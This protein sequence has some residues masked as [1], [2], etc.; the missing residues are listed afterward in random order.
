MRIGPRM[1]DTDPR[2]GPTPFSSEWNDAPPPP[3]RPRRVPVRR[4]WLPSVLPAWFPSER[5]ISAAL[6][7]V[8]I[9]STAA[10]SSAGHGMRELAAPRVA[11][12]PNIHSV[13][14]NGQPT[15]TPSGAQIVADAST[16]AVTA[17]A[18]AETPTPPVALPVNAGVPSVRG[19][20]SA[21][22]SAA[23]SGSANASG[24]GSAS[25]SAQSSASASAAGSQPASS[26]SGSAVAQG[27]ATQTKQDGPFPR[28]ADGNLFPQN[29]I[30]AYYG[31]PD[32][33]PA[34]NLMGVLG[35]DTIDNTYAK[36]MDQVAA[37]QQADPN[38]NVIPAF[39]FI[40]TVAQQ[41]PQPDGSYLTDTDPDFIQTYIDFAA[42]HDMLVFID[43]Q[44]GMRGVHDEVTKLLP[45]L[46]EPNVMLAIDPEFAIHGDEKPGEDF[47][48]I[49]ADDVNWTM[50]TLADLSAEKGIPNKVL[51]VHQFRYDMISDKETIENVP[52]IELVLHADGHGPPSL[53]KETYGVVVTQWKDRIHF[54][55]GF[56]VFYNRDDPDLNKY[57]DI[58]NMT[59]DEILQLDPIPY[60][61]SYQ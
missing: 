15:Q 10:F 46:A 41:N 36:L 8:I 12:D 23:A 3:E 7:L 60:Y 9:L 39:E 54:W 49:S 22:G 24:S 5:L 57:T 31:H 33:D 56:K 32:N 50:H 59:P 29:R 28:D 2:L 11:N 25:A 58:P 16:V 21:G 45:L 35:M 61:I 30:V 43:V 48:H 44:V 27:G 4:T 47:G 6:V 19:S 34:N 20:A 52:G 38:T 26:G 42:K 13:V 37:W 53:K 55:A 14:I 51:M 18:S 1:K 17:P 40:A